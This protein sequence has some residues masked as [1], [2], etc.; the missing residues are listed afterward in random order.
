M[1][2]IRIAQIGTSRYSHGNDV[3]N[4][5]NTNENYEIVG[6]CLPEN[7]DRKCPERMADLEGYRR[8]TLEE[9]LNDPTIDAVSVETEEYALARYALAAVR[10]GKHLHLEKPGAVSLA[11]F[12]ELIDEVKARGTVLH[13]GY[14]YR[15][16]PAIVELIQQVKSGEL[17]EITCVEAQMNCFHPQEMR[18]WLATYKGGMTYFL[19]CHI[20]D[21]IL[22]IQGVPDR[23]LP[24]NKCSGQGVDESEDIGMVVFEYPHGVS[25]AKT[26]AVERGG[27]ARRQLVVTGSKATVELRPLEWYPDGWGELYTAK[28]ERTAA[29]WLVD[30]EPVKSDLFPRYKAMFNAFAAMVRG[31]IVNPYTPDYELTLFKT[32]Q[33]ACGVSE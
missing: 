20:I 22:T 28:T 6:Y 15:Y 7:E 32:I 4:N 24:L 26:S 9:I 30:A 27:F 12:E 8:L 14:M 29:D 21:L 13:I 23:I 19:G 11:D 18:Q 10:A 31:E 3:V 16:N 2:K 5:L 17:G 25:F 1:G 33:K